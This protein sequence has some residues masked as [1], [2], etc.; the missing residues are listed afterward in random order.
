MHPMKISGYNTGGVTDVR[1]F[2]LQMERIAPTATSVS[3][4]LISKSSRVLL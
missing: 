1:S 3:L 2:N 4:D